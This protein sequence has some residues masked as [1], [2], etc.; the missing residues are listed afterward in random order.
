[1][2]YSDAEKGYP[3]VMR[4][5]YRRLLLDPFTRAAALHDPRASMYAPLDY[6]KA[7]GDEILDNAIAR[8]ARRQTAGNDLTGILAG[9]S[10]HRASFS[11]E[12]ENWLA[13]E[14]RKRQAHQNWL[15][16]QAVRREKP[17]AVL[18][19]FCSTYYFSYMERC[20]SCFQ[21]RFRK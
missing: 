7:R 14:E 18:C 20:P 21:A 6:A 13:E 15:A 9:L 5:H 8:T 3:V 11:G 10:S 17:T 2:P 1:M 4:E 12:T 19:P 16:E